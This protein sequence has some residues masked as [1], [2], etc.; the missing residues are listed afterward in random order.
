MRA[1]DLVSLDAARDFGMGMRWGI[2]A[3]CGGGSKW[4]E[5]AGGL[6]DVDE[7]AG[8]RTRWL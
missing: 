6:D 4:K 8:S 7:P 3:G 1:F 2:G 5:K